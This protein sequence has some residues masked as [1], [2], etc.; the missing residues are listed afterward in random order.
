MAAAHAQ[1][2]LIIM[3]LETLKYTITWQQR[4]QYSII[5]LFTPWLTMAAEHAQYSI[6]G[7]HLEVHYNV[8]QYTILGFHHGHGHGHG[9]GILIY[10]VLTSYEG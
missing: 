7:K 4:A 10:Y 6:I 8:P 1:Y 3:H 9:H 2:S 5:A